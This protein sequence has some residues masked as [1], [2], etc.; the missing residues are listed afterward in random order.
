VN[1]HEQQIA[2]LFD[3]AIDAYEDARPR[4]Q[5]KVIG[6]SELGTCHEMTRRRLLQLEE[7]D[8]P[9]SRRAAFIGTAI[10]DVVEEAVVNY[11][12]GPVLRQVEVTVQLPSGRWELVGHVD[13]VFLSLG[14]RVVVVDVKSKDGYEAIV[15]DGPTDQN[16]MQ[17]NLYA[18][19][20]WQMGLLAGRTAQLED[21]WTANAYI[22][23]S[24]GEDKTL[25]K[26]EPFS[27][28]WVHKAETFL[29]DVVYAAE[30]GEEA[31]K[32]KP[33]NWCE[34]FCEFY[35]DC[36]TLDTDVAGLLTDQET[37]RAVELYAEGQ[38]LAREADRMK[39]QARA[40]LR[41]VR[42]NTTTHSVRWTIVN[43]SW[44]EGYQRKDTEKI[45]IR[46]LKKDTG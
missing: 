28:E 46:P 7:T 1:E 27:W 11:C 10:G 43:G 33:R 18:L 6:V 22:D 21:V 15:R 32:D 19:G 30:N 4:T 16:Y 24:G 41:G 34:S 14:G 40:V 5:Q 17:R 36:R 20:L 2:E 25:V 31:S 35:S 44:V 39:K 26:A 8:V 23:R 37:V 12:D 3:A 29:D 9:K 13:L 42:G 45:E 38:E